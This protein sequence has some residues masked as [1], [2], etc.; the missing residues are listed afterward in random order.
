[1][2]SRTCG[3][4]SD[5]FTPEAERINRRIWQLV[6]KVADWKG[7]VEVGVLVEDPFNLGPGIAET[8]V[9]EREKLVAEGQDP[10]EV[11]KRQ[12]DARREVEYARAVEIDAISRRTSG[13]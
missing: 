10:D 4:R 2:D 8:V 11:F 9:R 12:R 3:K 5:R 13:Q 7:N 1:M 6:T